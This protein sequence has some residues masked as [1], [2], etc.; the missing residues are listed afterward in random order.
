MSKTRAIRPAA[1]LS[2]RRNSFGTEIE[3]PILR[4][5]NRT[6]AGRSARLSGVPGVV[7]PSG[8]KP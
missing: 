3:N 4:V 8:D 2:L 7:Q 5:W 6:A 1:R